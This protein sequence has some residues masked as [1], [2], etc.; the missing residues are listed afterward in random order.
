MAAFKGL[1]VTETTNKTSRFVQDENTLNCQNINVK[2]DIKSNKLKNKPGVELITISGNM[3]DVFY[4]SS[5]KRERGLSYPF[6]R[7]F[8]ISIGLTF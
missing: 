5:V 7:Q 6:S 3:S 1:L 4:L 8:S 2:Y